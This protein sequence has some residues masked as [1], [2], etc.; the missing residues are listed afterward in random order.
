M[1]LSKMIKKI[2]AVALAVS[3]AASSAVLTVSAAG[4][5]PD[6]TIDGCFN[7]KY[8]KGIGS[9]GNTLSTL[10]NA[11]AIIRVTDAI[12]NLDTKI[13]ISSY[14]LSLEDAHSLM[15]IIIDAH[16]EL[17][18]IDYWN[19]YRSD[20]EIASYIKPHY[21]H[22]DENGKPDAQRIY[23]EMQAFYDE[24]DRY[25]ALVSDELS[26]CRDDFS[27]ALLLHDEIALNAH[28]DLDNDSNYTFI[29]DNNGLCRCYAQVYAYLLGQ[30]GIKSEI[31]DTPVNEMCHEW[32]KICLDGKYYNVDLTWDDS[33]PDEPG[34]VEHG[35]FLFSDGAKEDHYGYQ[36]LYPS[37]DKK[38]DNIKLHNYNSKICKVSADDTVVYAVD[39]ANKR[40]VKYNYATDQET[41]LLNL[42]NYKWKADSEGTPWKW[43]RTSLETYGGYLFYNTPD[44]I[45][46]YDLTTGKSALL[47]HRTDGKQYF[48]IRIKNGILYSIVSDYSYSDVTESYL[49]DASSAATPVTSVT[50]SKTSASVD[51]GKTLVLSATL[52]PK[53]A[54]G[55]RTWSSSNES[56]AKI[57]IVNNEVY[58]RALKPGTATITVKTSNGKSAQ[59]KV[60]VTQ[61]ASS[62][63]LSKTSAVLGKG[64]TLTLSTTFTPS[65]TTNKTVTWTTSNSKVA[66]VVN[67]KITAKGVGTATITAKTA[68][69]KTATCKVTVKNAPTKITLSKTSTTIGVGKTYTLT[70]TLPSGTAS[71]KVTYTSSNKSV[72]TVS[73]S[74]KIT[75]KKVGTA[76]ITVTTFNGK[77]A[78][79]K[80]TVKNLP[81]SVKLNKTSATVKK[82]GTLTLKATVSPSKNVISTVTWT[83]SNTKVATV[84]NGKITAK[85]KGTAVI[86][87]KT[88]NGK[89]AKCKITV[90]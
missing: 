11:E 86:T 75:A 64:E 72:A 28:Y 37:T 6:G 81:T 89:T 79:C 74:G 32:M 3:I 84:K 51:V 58:V 40:L 44:E 50:I 73:S 20:D 35:Y 34:K 23:S 47:F 83:S 1:K 67:G 17:F 2:S 16:P 71:N 39:N 15:N 14:K 82:G 76:T 68:N 90:K 53:D 60:T 5:T 88:T 66:T 18:F 30:L 46:R 19:V 31:I 54:L 43:G 87:V 7:Y 22:V 12:M 61:P 38:Y 36:T 49:C 25:L 33:T 57:D 70:K 78:T 55:Y 24:A 9:D 29:K 85:A 63:K 13:D 10:D 8:Y 77:K 62:I 26:V 27:K 69:G 80:V 45:Y 21:R 41:T 65:N 42:N 48:G 59:C 52:N 4:R 56:V